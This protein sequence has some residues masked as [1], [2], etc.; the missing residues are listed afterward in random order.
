MDC[1]KLQGIGYINTSYADPYIYTG[2]NDEH[3]SKK[4]KDTFAAVLH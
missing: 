1:R 2:L 4:H 3:V